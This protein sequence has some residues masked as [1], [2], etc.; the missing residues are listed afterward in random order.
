M[1]ACIEVLTPFRIASDILERDKQPTS[2]EVILQFHILESKLLKLREVN[3]LTEITNICDRAL[4]FLEEKYTFDGHRHI[5]W[6]LWPKFRKLQIIQ[7][8]I[9]REEIFKLIE[10]KFEIIASITTA[11]V[12]VEE[13]AS[14]HLSI[15][16]L[17]EEGST[18]PDQDSFI[19]ALMSK[20]ADPPPG[21]ST[22]SRFA[23]EMSKYL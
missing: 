9:E 14:A 18:L 8:P 13:S 1:D 21:L 2:P 6:Y 20:W 5:A 16:H 23:D 11:T 22:Q 3:K 7:D 17:S 4:K 19:D 12:A 15:L 10:R